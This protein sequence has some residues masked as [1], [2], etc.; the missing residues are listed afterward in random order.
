MLT[1]VIDYLIYLIFAYI[2]NIKLINYVKCIKCVNQNMSKFTWFYT[3]NPK[4]PTRCIT[5][6]TLND[7]TQG[8]TRNADLRKYSG[9]PTKHT[10]R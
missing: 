7:Y 3:T 10:M 9:A 4:R 8:L 5:L 2:F 6:N 1:Y